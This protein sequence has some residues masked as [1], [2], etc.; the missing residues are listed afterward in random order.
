[1][2]DDLDRAREVLLQDG[3]LPGLSLTAACVAVKALMAI[4]SLGSCDCAALEAAQPA[5]RADRF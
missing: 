3:V 1:M 4:A 5:I 2:N